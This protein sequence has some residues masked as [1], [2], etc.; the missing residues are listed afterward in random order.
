MEIKASN[1]VTLPSTEAEYKTLSGVTK[2]IMFVKQV[3]ETMGIG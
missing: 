1:S 3:L 2:E